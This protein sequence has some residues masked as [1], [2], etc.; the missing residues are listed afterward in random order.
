MRAISKTLLVQE[1]YHAIDL[2]RFWFDKISYVYFI[3]L[4]PIYLL[5]MCQA[6]RFQKLS[7]EWVKRLSNVMPIG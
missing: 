6:A 5:Y 4:L 3:G 2:K 1:I 7:Q